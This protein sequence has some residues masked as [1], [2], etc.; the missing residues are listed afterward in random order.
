M[1][2]Q[3]AQH[4]LFKITLNHSYFS[5]G[6]ATSILLKPT[7]SGQQQISK[8]N[9]RY[10]SYPGGGTVV[11]PSLTN[12]TST[13]P[14]APANVALSMVVSDPAFM[15]Y[16]ALPDLEPGKVWYANNL[17]SNSGKL[18]QM[19]LQPARFVVDF[20]QQLEETPT[21]YT[22]TL[23][24]ARLNGVV[25]VQKTYNTL[26]SDTQCD[27][28]LTRESDGAYQL[29]WVVGQTSLTYSFFKCASGLNQGY[30][31]F[32]EW[33]SQQSTSRN[34]LLGQSYA[35]AFT[36]RKTKWQYYL[37]SK[38]GAVPQN[39][40]IQPVQVDGKTVRFTSTGTTSPMPD[41]RQAQ[42]F[43]ASRRIALS[44]DPQLDVV[45]QV[46]MF[47]PFQEM[48]LPCAVPS[49]SNTFPTPAPTVNDSYIYVY[50]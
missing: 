32:F 34:T 17:G 33:L 14:A 47:T 16:T 1:S 46:G 44:Q 8:L 27:V 29:T 10:F 22:R 31:G 11:Y 42:V 48:R 45:L 40:S 12:S 4:T 9:G 28:D 39:A 13:P 26:P 41:G 20:A 25:V 15:I 49:I 23:T 3:Q 37:V 5:D 21:A 18:S 2:L 30:F 6:L 7:A 43:V 36:A 38:T 50:F 19:Y 24:I 35:I